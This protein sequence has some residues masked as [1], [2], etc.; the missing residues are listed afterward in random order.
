MKVRPWQ[1]KTK[2]ILSKTLNFKKVSNPL[3]YV[4][5][6]VKEFWPTS[7]AVDNRTAIYIITMIITAYG[8]YIQCTAQERF[9]IS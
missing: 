8:L 5:H 1:K 2:T 4:A 9:P 6:K 3:K 7:W